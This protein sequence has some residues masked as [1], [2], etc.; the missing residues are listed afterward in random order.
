MMGVLMFL[1]AASERAKGL[2]HHPG[3]H[4]G[5][6]MLKGSDGEVGNREV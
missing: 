4:S 6:Q 1:S 2:T 5:D 3:F